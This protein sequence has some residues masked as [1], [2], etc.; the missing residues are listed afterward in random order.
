[1]ITSAKTNILA[2]RHG[3]LD[4]IESNGIHRADAATVV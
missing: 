1:M 4:I 3:Y 2:I